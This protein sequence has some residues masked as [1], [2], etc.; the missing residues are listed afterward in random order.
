MPQLLLCW[1]PLTFLVVRRRSV[2]FPR[3]LIEL[4]TD[5]PAWNAVQRLLLRYG[6]LH[7][8]LLTFWGQS[9]VLFCMEPHE[10]LP[11][12]ASLLQQYAVQ[13]AGSEEIMSLLLQVYLCETTAAPVPPGL[14]ASVPSRCVAQALASELDDDID[15]DA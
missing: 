1:Y 5:S 10:A 6:V 9:L 8:A 13:G 15:T 2:Y 14:T 3:D 7:P 11:S 12:A 4:A